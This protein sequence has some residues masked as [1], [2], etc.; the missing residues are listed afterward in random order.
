[1]TI[2]EPDQNFAMANQPHGFQFDVDAQVLNAVEADEFPPEVK[3]DVDGLMWLG[4]LTD[5]FDLYG[6]SF[7][8]RT[9]TRGERLAIT[10]ITKEY[11][12][13]LG[14]ADAYQTAIV[15]ASLMSID[16][17]PLVDL[18]KGSNP[19]HRIK[20]NFELVQKWYDP[21]IESLYERI[22]QLMVRQQI[23]FTELRSK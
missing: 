11:E 22:S 16:G 19:L 15:A 1:M 12:E 6:H 23:A 13:T 2:I 10:Q 5:S 21:V 14:M 18:H 7:V 9:L 8:I 3:Q 20:E 17:K 4:Y